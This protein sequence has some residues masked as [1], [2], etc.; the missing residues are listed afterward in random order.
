MII[1]QY[2]DTEDDY[3]I[4]LICLPD[5]EDLLSDLNKHRTFINEN[6]AQ[7]RRY[8]QLENEHY[9]EEWEKWLQQRTT[10]PLDATSTMDLFRML[11]DSEDQINPF[12][13]NQSINTEKTPQDQSQWLLVSASIYEEDITNAFKTFLAN[14]GYPAVEFP[15]EEYLTIIGLDKKNIWAYTLCKKKNQTAVAFILDH[16]QK[17]FTKIIKIAKDMLESG[18]I[19]ATL[20]DNPKNARTLEWKVLHKSEWPTAIYDLIESFIMTQNPRTIK[21]HKKKN[22]HEQHKKTK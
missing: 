5:E 11:N 10:T 8:L 16:H 9:D 7:I 15:S 12:S 14:Q 3:R 20:K 22:N 2:E 19:I 1:P 13:S 6:I 17:S 4:M 21:N 18:L